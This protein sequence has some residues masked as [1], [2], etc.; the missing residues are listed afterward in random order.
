MSSEEWDGDQSAP[1]KRSNS[2][3]RKLK[4][5]HGGGKGMRRRLGLPA[6]TETGKIRRIHI[7]GLLSF[8]S[9]A[10]KPPNENSSG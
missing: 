9:T 6:S 5:Q 7:L 4:K 3:Y 2:V 8:P 1:G 10:R